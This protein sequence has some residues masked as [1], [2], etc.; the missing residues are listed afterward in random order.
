MVT[1]DP[2]PEISHDAPRRLSAG[3]RTSGL[4]HFRILALTFTL[5]AAFPAPVFATT[6]NVDSTADEVDVTPGDGA[7]ATAGGAC[8]LRAAVQEANAT[9]G[10]DTVALPAG[11]YFLTIAGTDNTADAGDLDITDPLTITGAGARSTIIDGNAIDRVFHSPTT[12]DLTMSG[13]TVRNGSIDGAGGGFEKGNGKLTLTD[14]TV[15][16]NAATGN[17]GGIST[18]GGQITLTSVTLANNTAANGGASCL[19]ASSPCTSARP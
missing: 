10:L 8:T 6:F 14:V 18:A 1:Q 4:A 3:V 9:A 15:T 13:V 19:N 2:S 11:V 12:D 5:T 16:G 7:C 17:G